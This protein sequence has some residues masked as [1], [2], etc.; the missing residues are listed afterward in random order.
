MTLSTCL[1]AEHDATGLDRLLAQYPDEGSANLAYT[2]ALHRFRHEGA[3]RPATKALRYALRV[4]AFVPAYLLGEKP[5]PTTLPEYIGMGDEREAEAFAAEAKAL[6]EETPD[7]PCGVPSG[8]TPGGCHVTAQTCLSERTASSSPSCSMGSSSQECRLASNARRQDARRN[9]RPRP[10]PLA[11]MTVMRIAIHAVQ[12]PGRQCRPGP[13]GEA[14]QNIHVRFGRRE[15]AVDL[16]PGDAPEAHW[17]YDIPVRT[18]RD[19]GLRFGGPLVHGKPGNYCFYLSWGTVAAD[20]SFTLF[21]AAKLALADIDPAVLS[22]ALEPGRTLVGRLG[23][24]NATGQ[25]LCARV[26]PPLIA[27]SIRTD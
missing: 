4:N 6:W 24:T 23:L 21:R 15:P 17:E 9:Q 26:R 7:P 3:S 2:T 20:G 18:G 19:G 11:I 1:L 25:P 16:V 22:Q 12:L 8:G 27:W 10:T 13:S 5:L 14:Y